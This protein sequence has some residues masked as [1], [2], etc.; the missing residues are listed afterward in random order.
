MVLRDPRYNFS[1]IQALNHSGYAWRRFLSL[2]SSS[3]ISKVQPLTGTDRVSVFVVNDSMFERN[4]SKMVEMLSRFKD[5]ATGYYYKG[6][7]MLTLSWSDGHT[8]IPVDFSLLAS[9]KSQVKG[10]M[11]GIDKRTSS[12]K[13]R[14]EALLPAPKVIPAMIDRALSAGVQ[15]SYVLMDSYYLDLDA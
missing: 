14:M 1:G 4:R 8:F 2:L 3:T 5:H 7:R 15:A 6:F 12:Y 11:E 10:I 9:L 13:R